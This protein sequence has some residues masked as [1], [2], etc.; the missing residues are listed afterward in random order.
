M[1]ETQFYGKLL[2]T[3]EKIMPILLEIQ[4][5]YSIPPISAD[6][7]GVKVLLKHHSAINWKAVHSDRRGGTL[8]RSFDLHFSRRINPYFDGMLN[9]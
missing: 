7:N 5:K 9:L 6:D 8:Y 4:E 1:L 2:P 3:H